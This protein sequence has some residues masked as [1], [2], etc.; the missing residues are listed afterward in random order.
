MQFLIIIALLLSILIEDHDEDSV[1]IVDDFDAPIEEN[2]KG[3]NENF[4]EQYSI[5]QEE[6]NSYLSVVSVNS[7]NLIIKKIEVDIVKYPYLNWKWRAH[8][9][10]SQG[11]ESVK[12]YCDVTA[13]IALLTNKSRFFP[14][15]IK[16]SWS[17]TLD[18]ETRSRSPFAIWPARCD[19]RVLQSGDAEVGKWITEKVN[20]L[21]DYKLFYNK[22][23]VKSKKIRAVVIMSDSDNTMSV[24]EADYDN[25][26]F[27]KE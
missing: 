17:T 15:S 2:W 14:K 26:Y 9:L 4:D 13:S 21:E 24:S 10:P 16:Y 18:K 1:Y 5:A 23:E 27:S 6:D 25:I 11:D 3:R 19:I 20:I 8:K 22:T 7:D 12:Q